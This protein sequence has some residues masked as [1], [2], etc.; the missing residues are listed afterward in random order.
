M[1]PMVEISCL[2]IHSETEV[3]LTNLLTGKSI[4]FQVVKKPYLSGLLG[5]VYE[6][7]IMELDIKPMMYCHDLKNNII[8]IILPWDNETASK[9]DKVGLWQ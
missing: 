6:Y 9:L 5:Y 2:L 1:M 7:F 4:E 3:S 8:S